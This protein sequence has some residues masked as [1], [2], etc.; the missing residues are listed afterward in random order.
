MIVHC[1]HTETR[2]KKM[3][4]KKERER[5]S[6]GDNFTKG[7]DTTTKRRVAQEDQQI[8]EEARR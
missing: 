7:R 1:N 8:S 5:H 2:K 3:K 4:K 6:D